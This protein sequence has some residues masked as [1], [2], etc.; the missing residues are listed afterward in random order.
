METAIDDLVVKVKAI[1]QGS[2][3]DLLLGC[4]YVYEQE[5]GDISPRT[6]AAIQEAD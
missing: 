3:S 4:G 5:D 1:A 6:L 2:N